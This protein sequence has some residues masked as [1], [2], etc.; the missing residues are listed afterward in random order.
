MSMSPPSMHQEAIASGAFRQAAPGH[1]ARR[2]NS[3]RPMPS[4]P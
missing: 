1:G 2:Q 3:M 4:M